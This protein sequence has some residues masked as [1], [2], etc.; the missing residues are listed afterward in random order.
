MLLVVILFE[1][2]VTEYYL[3]YKCRD[4]QYMLRPFS[5]V[6]T[7]LYY[8]TQVL[9]NGISSTCCYLSVVHILHCACLVGCDQQYL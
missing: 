3:R 1:V 4:Q 9:L 7:L 8:T 6:Y 2:C 5:F